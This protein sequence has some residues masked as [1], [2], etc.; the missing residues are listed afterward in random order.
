[1]SSV[2]RCLS[3]GATFAKA[4]G[5][6]IHCGGEI[7][8]SVALTGVSAKGILGRLGAVADEVTSGGDRQIRYTAPSGSQSTSALVG[9]EV[10]VQVGRPVDI[11][12][13]GESRVFDR[14]ASHLKTDGLTVTPLP[15]SDQVGEDRVLMIGNERVT[16]QIV[17]APHD[18]SFW[19]EVAKGFGSVQT[20]IGMAAGWVNDAIAEKAEKYPG[21]VKQSM[22]LAVDIAHIGILS[23]PALVD[24]YLVAYGDPSDSYKFAGVWLVGPTENHCTRLGKS[25]W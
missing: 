1:M 9:G 8:L 4:V 21:S 16:L 3:C 7:E 10:R 23:T 12:R 13:P 25:R 24:S 14:V 22:L 11:G 6:C 2:I 19:R 5:P 18:P 15:A 17:T 20:D